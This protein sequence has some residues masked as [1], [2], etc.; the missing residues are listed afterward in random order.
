MHIDNSGASVDISTYTESGDTLADLACE[1]LRSMLLSGELSGGAIV[2]DRRLAERLGLSRTPVREALG[3]LEGE[4]FLRREGRVLVVNTISVE[5]IMEILAV[6]RVMEAEAVRL[7]TGRIP[8]GRI[9]EIRS[10]ID[11]MRTVESVT[12]DQHWSVDDMVHLS[13]AQASGNRLIYRMIRDLRERTRMFGLTRIPRRFDP[14]KAEHLGIL[15]AMEEGAADRAA[16]LMQE[17]IEHARQGILDFIS[18]R[19]NEPT[20]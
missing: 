4:G 14:G 2:Q 1:K 9:D 12:G 16:A 10:A 8:K 18:G 6:R 13:I 17:H 7:A 5:D 20:H 19:S 3:R 15:A 11:G